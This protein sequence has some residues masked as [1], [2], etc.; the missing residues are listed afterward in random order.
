LQILVTS[1]FKDDINSK[2]DDINYWFR[3]NSL[4]LNF[5]KTYFVQFRTKN[6]YETNLKITCDN[7]LIKETKNTKILGLNI[8][9]SLSWKDHIEQMMFKKT[10]QNMLCN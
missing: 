6:R 5:G 10:R 7:K 1:K 9:S 8:D 2:I 4:S 3:S